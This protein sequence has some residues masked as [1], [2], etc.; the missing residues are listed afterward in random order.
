MS[1][2]IQYHRVARGLLISACGLMSLAMVAAPELAAHSHPSVAAILYLFFSP[3][4]HQNPMR[5]FTLEGYQWAVCQ[6]CSGI[7]FGLF[8]FLLLPNM[9][10]GLLSTP[11]QRRILVIGASSPLLLD[12]LLPLAGIWTNVPWS[13]FMSGV[14]FGGMISTLLLPG[15]TQFLCDA[16]WQRLRSGRSILNGGSL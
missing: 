6:R 11:R 3:V 14:I 15:L 12:T 7:Y 16:P 13:R 9:P 10:P 5:S 4:C 1:A 2:R 8:V